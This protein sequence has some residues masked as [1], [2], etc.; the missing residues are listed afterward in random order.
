[1]SDAETEAMLMTLTAIQATIVTYI[2]QKEPTLA[3]MKKACLEMLPGI[4]E[5]YQS[6]LEE[7]LRRRA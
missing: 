7:C 5:I 3:V 2:D 1:M 6:S 4:K